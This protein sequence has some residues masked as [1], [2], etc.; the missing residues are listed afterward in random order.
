M[1]LSKTDT[2]SHDLFGRKPSEVLLSELF[3]D[4]FSAQAGQ[5]LEAFLAALGRIA[6]PFD[7]LEQLRRHEFPCYP[8]YDPFRTIAFDNAR[9]SWLPQGRVLVA[10]NAPARAAAFP[11]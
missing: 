11:K 4:R 3:V 6:L 9:E 5:T 7:L 1:N 8:T 2:P 10:A